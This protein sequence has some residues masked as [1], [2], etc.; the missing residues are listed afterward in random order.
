MASHADVDT[1]HF[2]HSSGGNHTYLKGSASCL[3]MGHGSSAACKLAHC[4]A[5]GEILALGALIRTGQRTALQPSNFTPFLSCNIQPAAI[6]LH[7]VVLGGEEIS[8]TKLKF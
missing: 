5:A 2:K 7:H 1:I 3:F 6:R 4:A 8:E